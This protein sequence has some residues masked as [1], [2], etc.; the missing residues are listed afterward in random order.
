MEHAVRKARGAYYTDG[1]VADFLV[2]WAIRSPTDRVLDPCFGDGIFLESSLTHLSRLGSPGG[3][4]VTGVELH[5]ESYEMVRARL[6]SARPRLLQ[7]DF[8]SFSKKDLG[9]FQAVVGN[10]PFIRYQKF[11]GDQR[12]RALAKATAAGV[13][14]SALTSSWAPF[15]AHSTTFIAP[16]GRLAMV[17]PAE[18][19]HAAYPRPLLRHLKDLFRRILILA[20]EKRLFPELNE[21][22][23]LLLADELGARGGDLR[24]ATL[25]DMDAL[26][27]STHDPSG[28]GADAERVQEERPSLT[29]YFLPHTIRTLY[30]QLTL[31][32]MVIRL[33]SV[34]NVGIGYVTGDNRFFHLSAAESRQLRIPPRAQRPAVCRSAWLKG[35]VFSRSDWRVLDLGQR[36]KR[37]LSLTGRGTEL[38]RGGKAYLQRGEGGGVHR[39]H[40][41][42]TRNP[43][44]VVPGV[45]VP[46]L[47]LSY[48]A[49]ERPVL[50]LNRAG[51][52]CP[53]TL[54]A[55]KAL[56]LWRHIVRAVPA[57]WCNSLTFLSAEIEGHSLGGG[58]LK[59]EPKEAARLV[60]PSPELVSPADRSAL[61]RR[62][63]HL[64]RKHSSTEARNLLDGELLQ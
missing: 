29:T 63:D 42:R 45:Q 54:L 60:I 13:H 39:A 12:T 8:F 20:F 41:C 7:G 10:P 53:N 30:D 51:V 36:E 21:D 40:Q 31:S 3:D 61:I 5:T 49:H 59:V 4:G 9:R 50:A 17:A 32:Q 24:I 58:M 47:F 38:P 19:C 43:W 14:L 48:M 22:T 34:A 33:G 6:G 15:I 46:D 56:P 11:S 57:V 25:R 1:A 44:Y 55:V 35:V 37:L 16:G 18:I 26:G 27:D 2:R 52:V 64:C 23:V 62:V 28:Y